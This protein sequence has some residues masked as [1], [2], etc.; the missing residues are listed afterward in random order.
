MSEFLDLEGGPRPG[1]TPGSGAAPAPGESLVTI[2]ETRGAGEP[3]PIGVYGAPRPAVPQRL[4]VMPRHRGCGSGAGPGLAA[5]QGFRRLPDW[6][7]VSL[8]GGCQ[9]GSRPVDQHLK[10]LEALGATI[11]LARGYIVAECKRLK[12]AEVV[13]DYADR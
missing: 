8:P 12:G 7:K 13:F 4:P 5:A 2:G 9:I 6:L 3:P 10:G 11:K 1:E